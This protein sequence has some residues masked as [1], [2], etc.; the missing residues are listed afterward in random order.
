MFRRLFRKAQPEDPR[1]AVLQATID[2]RLVLAQ[3]LANQAELVRLEGELR[4]Q[5]ARNENFVRVLD[6]I[7]VSRTRQLGD[8]E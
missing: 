6:D 3:V 4:D 8:N 7:R 1:E 5:I 2:L